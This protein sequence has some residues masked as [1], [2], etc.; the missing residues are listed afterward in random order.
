M[1]LLFGVRP[2]IKITVL[3]MCLFLFGACSDSS[4]SLSEPF[5]LQPAGDYTQMTWSEAFDALHA[6]FSA[7]YAFTEW[8]GIDW[9]AIKSVTRPKI[10]L[11]EFSS[12][13]DAI[14][15]AVE[16]QKQLKLKNVELPENRRM[17]F[18]IGVNLGDVIEKG[19]TICGD[20]V[21][22]A[23]RL[24]SLADGGG[25]CISGTAF[26]QVGKKLPLGYK[27]LQEIKGGLL[28]PMRSYLVMGERSGTASRFVTGS[29]RST[30]L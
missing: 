15:A 8:K 21:N 27:Y 14:Q 9:E 28:Q 17:T 26:D 18:R 10:V 20:G 12:V 19:D 6:Q 11:A 25:I 29:G 24:E 5:R 4:S 7:A 22:I 16:I 1:N 2:F 13:V 3:S 23:A 30:S